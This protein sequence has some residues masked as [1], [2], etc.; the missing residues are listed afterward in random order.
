MASASSSSSFADTPPFATPSP[1]AEDLIPPE[2]WYEPWLRFG[3]YLGAIFQ[4][5]CV[6][7]VVVLPAGSSSGGGGEGKGRGGSRGGD[8]GGASD[9]DFLLEEVGQRITLRNIDRRY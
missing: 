9:S 6:L 5:V 7:A 2:E 8:E 3:L 4:L 1:S